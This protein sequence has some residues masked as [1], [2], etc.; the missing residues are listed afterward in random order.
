MRVIL[1]SNKGTLME[2]GI[3]P[4]ITSNM[5]VEMIANAKMITYDSSIPSDRRLLS[6]LE[7]LLSIIVSFGTAF[8]YV[9]AGMYGSIEQIGTFKA[10]CIVV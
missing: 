7:K 10:F 2:L 5:I 1:A 3:S 8:V 4:L 6:S 9:F